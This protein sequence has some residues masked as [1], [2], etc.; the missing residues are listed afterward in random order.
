[1]AIC[2][3]DHGGRTDG[4]HMHMNWMDMCNVR[5]SLLQSIILVLAAVVKPSTLSHGRIKP[6]HVTSLTSNG[7]TRR[8]VWQGRVGRASTDDRIHHAFGLGRE[9]APILPPFP[10]SS[11]PSSSALLLLAVIEVN[12]AN[13]SDGPF[14]SVLLIACNVCYFGSEFHLGVDD[15][16]RRSTE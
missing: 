10:L 13:G 14:R 6:R 9:S 2:H 8:I 11:S 16:R 7:T 12:R 15:R 4:R 3:D 1:M 5:F